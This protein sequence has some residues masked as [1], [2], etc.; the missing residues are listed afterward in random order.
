MKEQVDRLAKEYG[1]KLLELLGKD[2]AVIIMVG[3]EKDCH[4]E[5]RGSF[6]A[7][8]GLLSIGQRIVFKQITDGMSVTK[9]DK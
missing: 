3:D 7:K 5:A 4:F 9:S 2:G 1:R 8:L 6:L